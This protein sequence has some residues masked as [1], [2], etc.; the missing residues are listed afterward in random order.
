M[1]CNCQTCRQTPS[2]LSSFLD[3]T[4]GTVVLLLAFAIWGLKVSY[5]NL[6]G[7]LADAFTYR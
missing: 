3:C 1:N 5:R 7:W 4:L 6:K 2:L